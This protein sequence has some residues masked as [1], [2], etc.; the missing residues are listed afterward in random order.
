MKQVYKAYGT[1]ALNLHCSSK[2]ANF[3]KITRSILSF[4]KGPA[5]LQHYKFL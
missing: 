3:M 5:L 4:F 1:H 2:K